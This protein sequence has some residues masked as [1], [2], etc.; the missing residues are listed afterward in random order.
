MEIG[1]LQQVI[2]EERKLMGEVSAAQ[3]AVGEA[4]R[5]KLAEAIAEG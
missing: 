1:Q 5:C 4:A 3:A 2:D